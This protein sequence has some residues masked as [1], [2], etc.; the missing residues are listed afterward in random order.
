MKRML[1]VTIFIFSGLYVSAQN[2]VIEQVAGM[3]EIKQPQEVLFKR[4]NEPPR[5]K[6]RGI[7]KRYLI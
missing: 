5:G 4:A 1:L 7:C 2:A 3:V 6:P